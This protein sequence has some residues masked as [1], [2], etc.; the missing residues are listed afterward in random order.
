VVGGDWPR[1]G[2]Y[3]YVTNFFISADPVNRYTNQSTLVIE[4]RFGERAFLFAEY[5]GEFP[6][7]GGTSHLFNS[8][9]GYRITS[10][11]QIDFHKCFGLNSNAPTYILAV[12]Y[13]FRVDGLF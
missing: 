1:L 11:Q 2:Y 3:R 10:T 13:S 9:G 6:L 12:G 4:R 8:G 7:V 5:V